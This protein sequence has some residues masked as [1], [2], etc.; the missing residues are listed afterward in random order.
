MIAVITVL[1]NSAFCEDCDHDQSPQKQGCE[2]FVRI[3]IIVT[4]LRNK[5][6][7]VKTAIIVAVLY[8]V[9]MPRPGGYG[10]TAATYIRWAGTP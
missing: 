9:A 6:F 5:T 3:D 7:F 10:S 2:H 4:V 8:I 1:I